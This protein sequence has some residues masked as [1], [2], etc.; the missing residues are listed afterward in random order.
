[1]IIGIGTDIVRASRIKPED[2]A[3]LRKAFTPDEIIY[4]K[5]KGRYAAAGIFA[6]K[7]AIAKAL[8]TGFRGFGPADVEITYDER[9]RPVVQLYNNAEALAKEKKARDTHVS[10]AHDGEYA[11]AFAVIE[12]G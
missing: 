5:S 9:G 11:T 2:E 6:A 1:M 8:G 3:F 12:G 4:I 7:E 10:I